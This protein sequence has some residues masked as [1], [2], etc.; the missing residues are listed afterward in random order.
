LN[1]TDEVEV[2]N[3][4]T[5]KLLGFIGISV[6]WKD[7]LSNLLPP[8]ANGIIATFANEC[9]PTFSFQINGPEAHYLGR[10]DFLDPLYEPMEIGVCEHHKNDRVHICEFGSKPVSVV[11]FQNFLLDLGSLSPNRHSYTGIPVL[12]NTC[13]FFYGFIRPRKWRMIT[14]QMIP[15]CSL[16]VQC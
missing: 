6:Y 2:Q 1:K 13:P 4:Q 16:F 11:L 15:S 14:K 7:L 5:D 3:P 12:N 8:G 9:S 10:G